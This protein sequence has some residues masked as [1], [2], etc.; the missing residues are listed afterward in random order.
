MHKGAIDYS[1]DD[2]NG[3]IPSLCMHQILLNNENI[4][5]R[6]SQHCLNLNMYEGVKKEVVKLKRAS[7][8]LSQITIG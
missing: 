6:H 7:S 2:V 3:I 5:S 4:L 1:T 8:I